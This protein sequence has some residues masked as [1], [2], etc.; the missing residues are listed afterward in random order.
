M[1]RIILSAILAASTLVSATS[2]TA[3]GSFSVQIDP[4]N[5]EEANA[6]RT[7]LAIFAIARAL[8]GDASVLQNGN[9]NAAGI[10][11]NGNGNW[12]VVQQEGNGHTG[13]LSQNGDGNAYGIFQFGEGTDG[14]VMQNG[15]YGTGLLFQFGW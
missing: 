12:G 5:T 6:I 11:Q 14:Q 8:E 1:K 15:D 9:G 10:G 7:G 2:A 3:A 13:V 4:A